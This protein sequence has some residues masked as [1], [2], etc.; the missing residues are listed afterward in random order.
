MAP[1]SA[2]LRSFPSIFFAEKFMHSLIFGML[3]P[4]NKVND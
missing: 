2:T 1:N 4:E 3:L